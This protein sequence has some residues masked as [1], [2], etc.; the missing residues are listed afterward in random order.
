MMV[1]SKQG[2]DSACFTNTTL[3]NGERLSG[4]AGCEWGKRPAMKLMYGPGERW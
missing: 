1:L 4:E 3:V 2:S